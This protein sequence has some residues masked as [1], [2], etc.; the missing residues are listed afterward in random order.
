M[1]TAII[2]DDAKVQLAINRNILN[3]A[4]IEVIG[5]ATNGVQ[6]LKLIRELN[7]SIALLDYAMCPLTGAE[8][9]IAVAAEGLET[10]CIFATGSGQRAAAHA[11][12]IPVLVKPF[13]GTLLSAALYE[14][15]LL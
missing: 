3:K 14:V 7:P 2:A 13:N 9:A 4:G 1:L 12:G 15:G 5:T 6:A 10:K 8:V 11:Y